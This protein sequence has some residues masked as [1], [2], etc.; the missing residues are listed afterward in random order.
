MAA[1]EGADRVTAVEVFEP[2]AACAK[3]IID[4][5]TYRNKIEVTRTSFV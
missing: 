2:M 5:T 4:N 1:R 3:K